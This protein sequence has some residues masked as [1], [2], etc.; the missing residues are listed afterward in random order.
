MNVIQLATL[1]YYSI[2]SK[3]IRTMLSQCYL[4]KHLNHSILEIFFFLTRLIFLFVTSL[5]QD[6]LTFKESKIRFS[7]IQGFHLNL[8]KI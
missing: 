2:N 7:I 4:L 6:P 1:L 5:T 3:F 8:F